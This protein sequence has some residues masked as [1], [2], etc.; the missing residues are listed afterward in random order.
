[1][2]KKE[3]AREQARG[4]RA[5]LHGPSWADKMMIEG[6]RRGIRGVLFDQLEERFGPLPQEIRSHIESIESVDR[7]RRLTRRARTAKSLKG[8]RLG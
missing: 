5:L 8:L 3:E 1:M 7:L 2:T 6:E 4:I